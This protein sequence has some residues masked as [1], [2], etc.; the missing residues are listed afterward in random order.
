LPDSGALGLPNLPGKSLLYLLV[1]LRTAVSF[2][3]SETAPR[4]SVFP[5]DFLHLVIAFLLHFA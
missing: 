3:I 5:D 4:V 1:E 2:F